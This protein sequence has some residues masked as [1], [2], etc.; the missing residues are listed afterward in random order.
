MYSSLLAARD[1]NVLILHYD[2]KVFEL[3]WRKYADITDTHDKKLKMEQIYLPFKLSLEEM[4][5]IHKLLG[6]IINECA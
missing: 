3:E 6:R 2:E 1:N 5:T 4:K